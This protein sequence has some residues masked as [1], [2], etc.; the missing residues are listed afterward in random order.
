MKKIKN[1]NPLLVIL[2]SVPFST[3]SFAAGNPFDKE[4]TEEMIQK[5]SNKKEETRTKINPMDLPDPVQQEK[6]TSG[7]NKEMR[8]NAAMIP[9]RFNPSSALGGSSDEE[10]IREV[11]VII[12]GKALE[13]NNGTKAYTLMEIQ[14]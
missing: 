4:P 8:G 10:D 3:A 11:K 13:Y 2:L 7:F 12:N 5:N 1:I 14:K 9:S 6:I